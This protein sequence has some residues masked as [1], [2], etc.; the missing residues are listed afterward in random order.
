MLWHVLP[1][2]FLVASVAQCYIFKSNFLHS[3]SYRST[4]SC[5]AK[6]S[7][8][9]LQWVSE[10]ADAKREASNMIGQSVCIGALLHWSIISKWEKTYGGRFCLLADLELEFNVTVFAQTQ[11]YLPSSTVFFLPNR[12]LLLQDSTACQDG[13]A[14]SGGE[15]TTC[16]G[17]PWRLGTMPQLASLPECLG[18]MPRLAT[19]CRGV[20]EWCRVQGWD[21]DL[22]LHLRGMLQSATVFGSDAV[23]CHDL[24]LRLTVMP[25]I[26]KVCRGVW[27]LYCNL[28]QCLGVRPRFASLLL[29][30][31]VMS[32]PGINPWSKKPCIYSIV[33][34]QT[35]VLIFLTHTLNRT[36]WKALSLFTFVEMFP[37][38]RWQQ[39]ADAVIRNEH[40][41][42]SQQA[43]LGFVWFVLRLQDLIRYD[44][45]QANTSLNVSYHW[46]DGLKQKNVHSG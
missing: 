41:K 12:C 29:R 22:P 31:G 42:V 8:N 6:G 1:P 3:S 21:W 15:P 2:R 37:E 28:P 38:V 33:Y 19:T 13:T 18:A 25:Q 44:L 36:N 14:K 24:P 34:S 20:W 46:Q 17:R 5:I 45:P 4:S 9:H 23:T 40:V 30:L 27:G 11:V 43:A 16:H 39:S 26:A 32:W 35:V 7:E 10:E